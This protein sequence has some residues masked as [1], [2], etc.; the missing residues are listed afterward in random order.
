VDTQSNL[1]V[2]MWYKEY[3]SGP[4][5]LFKTCVAMKFVVDDDDDY[6]GQGITEV[7]G[8]VSSQYGQVSERGWLYTRLAIMIQG[9]IIR[10]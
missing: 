9:L 2:S 3:Y 4:E 7:N 6:D 8:N 1:N 10:C 5:V